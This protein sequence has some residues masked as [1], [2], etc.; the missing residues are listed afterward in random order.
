ML[1]CFIVVLYVNIKLLKLSSV[2]TIL[3][4]EVHNWTSFLFLCFSGLFY[5]TNGTMCQVGTIRHCVHFR[6][7]IYE[8][9]KCKKWSISSL[10]LWFIFK[11][12]SSDII[13]KSVLILSFWLKTNS[14]GRSLTK[15]QHCFTKYHIP[16]LISLLRDATGCNWFDMTQD[17]VRHSGWYK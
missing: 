11:R 1:F 17:T 7:F 12:K 2:K 13:Y 3:S 15:I 6:D 5:F 14:S 9:L 10:I 4:F 8:K 16:C